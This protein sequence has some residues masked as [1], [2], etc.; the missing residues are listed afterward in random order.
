M[1]IALATEVHICRVPSA[2][3]GI[4]AATVTLPP[5]P[6]A[7]GRPT[8]I[9][10]GVHVCCR[11]RIVVGGLV[12]IHAVRAEA[13]IAGT[14]AAEIVNVSVVT[15]TVGSFAEMSIVRATATLNCAVAG[16]V[17][18]GIGDV[19]VRY[20]GLGIADCDFGVG[21]WDCGGSLDLVVRSCSSQSREFQG[22][23]WGGEGIKVCKEE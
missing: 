6:R 4:G 11:V 5:D 21:G 14:T 19:N 20:R 3:V 1:P 18:K 9:V 12:E 23:V 22:G 17:G 13:A 8:T 2:D 10:T 15:A 16:A 7:L